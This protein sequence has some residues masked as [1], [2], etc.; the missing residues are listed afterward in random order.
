VWWGIF[1]FAVMINVIFEDS[2]KESVMTLIL[3]ILMV[4]LL[5]VLV[6]VSLIMEMGV[7]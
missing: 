3:F 2:D 6:A 5:L 7:S 1:I 4:T